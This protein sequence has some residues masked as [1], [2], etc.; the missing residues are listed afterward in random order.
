VVSAADADR[1]IAWWRGDGGAASFEPAT[2]AE[3][4]DRIWL[5]LGQVVDDLMGL[6]LRTRDDAGTGGGEVVVRSTVND[7]VVGGDGF[8]VMTAMCDPGEHVTGGGYDIPGLDGDGL[9][10]EQAA[11]IPQTGYP[12]DDAGGSGW[13][14]R[15]SRVPDDPVTWEPITVYAVCA[16]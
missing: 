7:V 16:R 15:V 9:A 13:A 4:N 8:V 6:D 12:V 10:E 2:L 5:T 1:A 11:V 3:A 14:V